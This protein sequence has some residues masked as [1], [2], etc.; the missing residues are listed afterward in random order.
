MLPRRLVLFLF[1]LLDHGKVL[2]CQ[3]ERTAVNYNPWPGL[4]EM[5]Q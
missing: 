2:H 5:Q 1:L 3:R 4:E